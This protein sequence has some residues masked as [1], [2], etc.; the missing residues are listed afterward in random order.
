[1]LG[2]VLAIVRPPGRHD[3]SEDHDI[4]VAGG[5]DTIRAC[6]HMEVRGLSWILPRVWCNHA[7]ARPS[8]GNLLNDV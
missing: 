5:D 7:N 4:L 8:C 1:M 3:S 2:Y 6:G